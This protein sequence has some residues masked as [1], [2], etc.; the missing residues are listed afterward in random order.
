[1]P[2]S[3]LRAPVVI[4]A[5]PRVEI[6][7]PIVPSPTDWES[8]EPRGFYPSTGRALFHGALLAVVLPVVLALGLVIAAIQLVVFKSPSRIFYTQPRAGRRG[9]AFRIFKFR[10]MRDAR[11][12]VYDSWSHG[13]DQQRVTRFG[14]FLRN[15]HLDEL[16]QMLNVLRGEMSLIGPRP[17]MVEIEA[18]AAEHVPGFSKRLVLKPGITGYAQITQGYTGR[19]V[20]AYTEKLRLNESYLER[21]SFAADLSILFGTIAWMARGRGW[22]WNQPRAAKSGDAPTA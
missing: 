22:R 10:T 21:I 2:S 3:T 11:G 20:E 7:P 13:L 9:E 12:T 1:M 4:A 5:V 19:C 17:E 14:R 16:P 15:S 8:L 18:W 6:A